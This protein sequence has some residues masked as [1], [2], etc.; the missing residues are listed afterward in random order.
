VNDPLQAAVDATIQR[1]DHLERAEDFQV[2][3]HR[4]YRATLEQDPKLGQRGLAKA[5][6]EELKARGLNE[7]EIRRAG[8]SYPS[9]ALALKITPATL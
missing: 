7:D 1:L 3:R 6:Q 4:A 9:V 2:V 5:L 8:V